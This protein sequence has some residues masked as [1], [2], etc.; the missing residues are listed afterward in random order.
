[1]GNAAQAMS[2]DCLSDRV[3]PIDPSTPSKDSSGMIRETCWAA[4]FE[5]EGAVGK[6]LL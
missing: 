4:D 1:M 5:P 3:L 6:N 2:A